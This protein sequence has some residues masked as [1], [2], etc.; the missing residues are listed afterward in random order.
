[1]V[2]HEIVR[3]H[4]IV[5]KR[6]PGVTGRADG[7]ALADSDDLGLPPLDSVQNAF[8]VHIRV[9]NRLLDANDLAS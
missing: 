7:S 8:H 9:H 2:R 5:E 3:C 6:V 1:M 4:Y